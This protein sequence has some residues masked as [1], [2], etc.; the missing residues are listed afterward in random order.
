MLG[1]VAGAGRQYSSVRFLLSFKVL[2]KV[3]INVYATTSQLV[4]HHSRREAKS[5]GS[6]RKRVAV[7]LFWASE[8][9]TFFFFAGQ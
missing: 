4:P 3:V 9:D 7:I 8:E 2:Q 1:G 5:E 6:V